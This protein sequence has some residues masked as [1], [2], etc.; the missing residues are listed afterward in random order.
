[1][2]LFV[3]LKVETTITTP[4]GVSFKELEARSLIPMQTESGY[5]V[6]YEIKKLS[7]SE[8]GKH[9]DVLLTIGAPLHQVS[10][11]EIELLVHQYCNVWT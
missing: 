9:F 3:P 11:L 10:D 4:F 2:S 8:I 5:E 1:M 7:F 6:S